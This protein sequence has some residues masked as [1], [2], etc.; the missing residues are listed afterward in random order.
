MMLENE[1]SGDY[2]T[3]T[4]LGIGILNLPTVWYWQPYFNSE[5]TVHHPGVWV[6]YQLFLRSWHPYRL[7]MDVAI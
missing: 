5:V 4:L 1:V 3:F 6:L 7:T 2:I